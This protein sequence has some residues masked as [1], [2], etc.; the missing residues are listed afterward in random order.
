MGTATGG[1]DLREEGQLMS[2]RT[3]IEWCDAMLDGREWR[4][5]PVVAAR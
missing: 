4:E 5:W 3:N 2:D 1:D